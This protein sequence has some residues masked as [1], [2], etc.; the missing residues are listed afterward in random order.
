MTFL[1]VLRFEFVYQVRR[2]LTW[3]YF[4]LLAVIAF[5]FVRTGALEDAL[6]GDFFVNSPFVIATVSV[7]GSLFWF[8]TAGGVSG[9]AGAR[10]VE[11]GMHPITYTAPVRKIEYLGGRFAAAFAVHALIMLAVPAGVMIAVYGPGIDPDVVGPFRIAAYVTA[12]AFIALPNAFVGTTVQ[13]AWAALGRRSIGS[14]VGSVFLFFVAYGGM[15]ALVVFL[16]RQDL[17]MFFDVFGQV[18]ITSDLILGWTPI[19]KSTRLITFTGPLLWSRLFWLGIAACTLVFTYVRFRTTHPTVGVWWSRLLRR[20]PAHAPT[21]AAPS[22]RSE[23]KGISIP[24]VEQAF[25]VATDRRQTLRIAR[26]SF[27]TIATSRAGLVP[28]TAIAALVVVVLPQNMENMGTPLLPRTEYV[29]SFLTAALTSPF[30]PWVIVPLLVALYAGELVWREREV[31]LGEIC[32]AAPVPD[33]VIFLGR[34]LGLSL[35]LVC[36]EVLL[37][38]A[39]VLVQVRMGYQAHEIGLYVKVLFGLQLPDY[40]L[41]AVLALTIHGL[42]NQKYFGHLIAVLAYASIVLIGFVGIRHNLLVYGG[43][44]AWFYDD[45]RGFGQS[46]AP[47]VWFHLYW[48]AWALLIAVGATLLWVRGK[49]SGLRPRLQMARGRFTHPMARMTAL[50]AGLVVAI[51][52]FIFY[53]TN[54]LNAYMTAWQRAERRAEYERRYVRYTGV[55]QPRVTASRLRVEI[56][57]ERRAVEIRGSYTLLNDTATAVDSIQ[58]ATQPG[59]ETSTVV[60]DPP[61]AE[62][63]NDD[64]HGHRI[65]ALD[66]PLQPGGSLRLDFEVDVEPKGFRNDGIDLSVVEKSTFFRSQTWLPAI[67]YQPTREIIAPAERRR[68]GLEQRPLFPLLDEAQQD[69]TGEGSGLDAD[70]I[71]FEAVVGTSGDQIAVAPGVLRR[72]WMEGGRRYFDYA[73]DAPIGTEQTFFSA[74]YAVHEERWNPSRG[75]G[76]GV[77]VQVYHHPKHA[78]NVERMLRSV[79]AC[80]ER[81]T[82]E[83]GPYPWPHLRLVENPGR[84]IGAHAS[85]STIDFTEGFTRFDPRDDP[86]GLDLPFAVIAHEMGHEW[87]GAQLPIA[88]VE[89]APLLSESAAWYSAMGVVKETYGDD[90]LQR[91]LRFFRQPYPIPPIRQSVPLLRAMDPYAAYRKGPFAF[92]A[93]AEYIGEERVNLAFRR[94]L[95]AHRSGTP[96]PATSR[97]LYRELEAVT[98]DSFQYLLRDLFEENTFWELQTE[99]ATSAQTGTDEWQVTLD[100]RARKVRVDPAGIETEVPMDEPIQIGV[101]A[102]ALPG[103][104]YGETLYL[105]RHRIRS[106]QQ[107]ITVTV[108]G[109]PSDAGIDPFH[110]LIELERFDNVEKVTAEK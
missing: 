24:Q 84:G 33:W 104:D 76:P 103:P 36:W 54:V 15:F 75:S 37:L 41:F 29:L 48:G 49:E 68:H 52:G 58:L 5:L 73:T 57:P 71:D 105:Q 89:G 23:S 7:F 22:E 92:R 62:L 3:V 8:V 109:R 10:D 28:L 6:F 100:L 12:Y 97:D 78:A 34:F 106:G 99:R 102:P 88:Y 14:Y 87:W 27:W 93:M 107:T 96:P 1:E 61:A 79:R 55:P 2:L 66:T 25:G 91:L 47:W 108:P 32:D 94:L 82:R 26:T 98:P 69:I 21:P 101:F 11:T 20:P 60:F 18:F 51:G 77:E 39:G 86:H 46:I 4:V 74:A 9:D 90:H 13:F 72:T 45:M 83:F 70:R 85:A 80:L 95:E 81:Y 56:Y 38:I 65:Y 42:A 50:A 59:V 30:T 31:G 43:A 44:P 17:A 19:E 35:I 110:L 40:L 53:N 63:V 67:G 16:G 64:E